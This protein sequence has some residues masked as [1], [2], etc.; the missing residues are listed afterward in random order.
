LALGQQ[1]TDPAGLIPPAGVTIVGASSDHLVLE[2]E[3]G[4]LVVGQEQRFGLHY[5]ALLRAMT[6][7]FVGRCFLGRSRCLGPQGTQAP[8]ERL[9]TTLHG[10][11]RF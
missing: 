2:Q 7:P 3:A 1:D 5:S 4:S 6:S 10:D 8:K 11:G 9:K